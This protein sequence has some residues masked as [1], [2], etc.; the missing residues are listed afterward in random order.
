MAGMVVQI[1]F[2]YF[3]NLHSISERKFSSTL[4]YP[5]TPQ[6]WDPL[7]VK[8]QFLTVQRE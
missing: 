7:L 2:S 4:H 1:F 5:S 6:G 3:L 8:S